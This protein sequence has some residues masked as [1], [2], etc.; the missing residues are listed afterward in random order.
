MSNDIIWRKGKLVILRPLNE[1]DVPLCQQNI[2]DPENS[3]FLM[4]TGPIGLLQEMEWYKRSSTSN[5]SHVSAVICTHD[6]NFIGHIGM[7]I[8]FA[9]GCAITGTLIGKKH[10]GKGYGTDAKMLIL[11]YAF[12]WLGLRK[13][14]SKII[15]FNGRSQSYAKKCGYRQVATLPKEHFRLGKWRD[16]LIYMVFR[17]EWLKVWEDY[18]KDWTP[19]WEDEEGLDLS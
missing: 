15:D 17:E 3:R 16:T 1:V 19:E 10:Q 5:P 9:R 18:T 4:L 2:N 13:V 6:G 12:N 14:T 7:D 11:D 8:D